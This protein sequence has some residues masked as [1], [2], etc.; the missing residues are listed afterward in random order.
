MIPQN[1]PRRRR[2]PQCPTQIQRDNRA[3]LLLAGGVAVHDGHLSVP[4][5]NHANR[6]WVLS[7]FL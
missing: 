2:S 1:L 3:E 6:L 7:R 5:V 4:E